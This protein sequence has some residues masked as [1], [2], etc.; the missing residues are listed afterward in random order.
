MGDLSEAIA[1]VRPRLEAPAPIG[2]RL[3]TLW[4]AVSAA[5]NLADP[6][7]CCCAPCAA[8]GCITDHSPKRP[9]APFVSSCSRSAIEANHRRS[10]FTAD[11]TDAA[12]DLEPRKLTV[13]EEQLLLEQ[14]R[15]N[16]RASE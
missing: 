16:N 5:R 1:Y 14:A 15:R 3:C 7:M 6:P 2:A 4:A 12:I 13:E 11:N 10:W 9:A 8:L